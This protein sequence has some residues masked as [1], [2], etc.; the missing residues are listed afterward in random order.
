MNT[1]KDFI[2]KFKNSKVANSKI[3]PNAI[4]DYLYRELEIKTYIPFRE[5]RAIVEKIVDNNLECKIEYP[6]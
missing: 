2:E 5:K 1:V 3:A 4:S 6:G